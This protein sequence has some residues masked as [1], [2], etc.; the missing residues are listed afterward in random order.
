MS[1][2][3]ISEEDLREMCDSLGAQIS[4]TSVKL[5]RMKRACEHLT[6]IQRPDGVEGTAPPHDLR[7]GADM[8]D[9]TRLDIYNAMMPEGRR[10]LGAPANDED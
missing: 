2:T 3:A 7:T 10:L 5:A 1:A 9:A 8:T 6:A 4:E